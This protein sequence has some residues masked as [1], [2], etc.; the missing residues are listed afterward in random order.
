M[1]E[2]RSLIAIRLVLILG[3]VLVWFMPKAWAFPTS[4][5]QLCQ[6]AIDEM[7]NTTVIPLGLLTAIGVVESGKPDP[8]LMKTTPWPWAV[9]VDGTGRLYMSKAEAIAGVIAA[10]ARGSTSIDVGCMQISLK[11]HPHAFSDLTAAFEPRSNVRYASSLLKSLFRQYGDW[12][13]AIQAYHSSNPEFGKPYGERVLTA[14]HGGGATSAFTH[15]QNQ[16]ANAAPSPEL[17]IDPYNVMT[18]EFRAQLVQS[19]AIST[20]PKH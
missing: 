19:A 2:G 6:A 15:E 8:K 13:A 7:G 5:Y 11:Y 9:D 17:A 14:W 3:V 10:Q 12:A 18:P 16:S 20:C 1:S 4:D